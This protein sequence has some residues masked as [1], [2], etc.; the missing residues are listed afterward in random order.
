MKKPTKRTPTASSGESGAALAMVDD[1]NV[2]NRA[3]RK[4]RTIGKW[5]PPEPRCRRLCRTAREGS[6]RN[7][8]KRALRNLVGTALMRLCPPY[9]ATRALR[10]LP[11]AVLVL[12]ARATG[13]IL[14]AADLAPAC[15]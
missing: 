3:A 8:M 12:L 6:S 10:V 14:V 1:R 11:V 2:A 13:A 5:Q 15:G 9:D 7:R 4:L